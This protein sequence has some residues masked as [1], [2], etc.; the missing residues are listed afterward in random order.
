[1]PIVRGERVYFR[2]SERGDIPLFVR[3]L[4]DAAT[5]SYLS[6][7]LPMSVAKNSGSIGCSSIRANRTSAMSISGKDGAMEAPTANRA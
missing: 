3:W 2:S 5:A 1:M 6:M 4:N 7:G